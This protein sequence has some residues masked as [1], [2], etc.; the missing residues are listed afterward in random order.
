MSSIDGPNTASTRSMSSIYARVL[1]A[2]TC[3]ILKS[4]PSID[5][6]EPPNTSSI[7]VKCSE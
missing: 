6:I 4:T 7:R 5:S 1:A 3:E 2:Q